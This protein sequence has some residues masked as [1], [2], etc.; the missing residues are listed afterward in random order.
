[1]HGDFGPHNLVSDGN[2]ITGVLDWA[3]MRLGDYLYDVAY[4]DYWTEDNFYAEAWC[5][6]A[7]K[8]GRQEPDFDDRIC[9]YKIVNVLNDLPVSAIQG[10]FES[11]GKTKERLRVILG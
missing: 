1:M 3:D 10:D 7:A 11:Y 5:A 9:C 6:Y 4:L 8:Q 2:V